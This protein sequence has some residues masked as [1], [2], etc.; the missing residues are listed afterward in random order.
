MPTLSSLQRLRREQQHYAEQQQ[1][2][3]AYE[4]AVLCVFFPISVF[5]MANAASPQAAMVP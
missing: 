1:Y 3:P 2:R 4:L 5:E